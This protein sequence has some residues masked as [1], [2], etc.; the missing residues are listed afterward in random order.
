MDKVGEVFCLQLSPWRL[1]GLC[2]LRDLT[3]LGNADVQL[4]M[5]P[6]RGSMAGTTASML[7]IVRSFAMGARCRRSRCVIC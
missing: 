7:S 4:M 6:G 1:G 2:R 3:Q 5:L